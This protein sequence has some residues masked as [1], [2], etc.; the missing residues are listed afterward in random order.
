VKS[1]QRG[2]DDKRRKKDEFGEIAE[3]AHLHGPTPKAFDR[4][5]ARRSGTAVTPGC[6]SER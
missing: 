3:L 5:E 2:E 4:A 1:N 6:M